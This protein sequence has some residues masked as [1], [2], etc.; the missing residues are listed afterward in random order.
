[1]INLNSP[2]TVNNATFSIVNNSAVGATVGTVTAS[3]PENNP[4]TFSIT[5][6]NTDTDND[7]TRPFAINNSGAITVT[8]PGDFGTNNSFNLT[9]TANDGNATG[10]GTIV[11]NLTSPV[12]RPPV[13]NNAVFSISKTSPNGTVVGTINATDPDNDP[14]TYSITAGNPDTDGDGILPF[15]ISSKTGVIT[16]K[17]KDDILAQTNPFNLTIQ[18]SD[19]ALN[20]TGIATINLNNVNPLSFQLKLYEDNNGTIGNEITGN[21]PI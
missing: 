20:A 21:N 13:V 12:N 6:G 18:A 10:N 15:E 2:P 9:V 3:D 17:D 16:V 14:L 4:L 19:G 5:N 8:D 11:V 1:V 7:G